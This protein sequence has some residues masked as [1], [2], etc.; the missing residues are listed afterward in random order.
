MASV[1]GAGGL[2]VCCLFEQQTV[3]YMCICFYFLVWRFN[4]NPFWITFYLQTCITLA[5]FGCCLRER[6]LDGYTGL[7]LLEK[8][9]KTNN[10]LG[11]VGRAI[12]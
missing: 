11:Q 1:K 12:Y 7:E 2:E 8:L 3:T 6:N 9:K 4:Q 5:D 10:E